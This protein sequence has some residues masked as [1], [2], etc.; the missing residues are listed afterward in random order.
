V[1]LLIPFYSF[2]PQI[3]EDIKLHI[4]EC[5]PRWERYKITANRRTGSKK[6]AWFASKKQAPN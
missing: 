5:A 6:E 3:V 2:S 4:V 1:C